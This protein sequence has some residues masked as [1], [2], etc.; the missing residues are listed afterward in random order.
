MQES[1]KSHNPRFAEL[2]GLKIVFGRQTD[3]SEDS[4][5]GPGSKGTSLFEAVGVA[6]V[7][8]AGPGD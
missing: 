8:M 5:R 1:L 6:V 3:I 2:V 7:G 4:V